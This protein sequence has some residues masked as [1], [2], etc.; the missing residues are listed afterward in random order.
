MGLGPGRTV[1]D[2]AAGT[3]KLSR[4]LVPSG[5]R[6]VAVEPVTAMREL[7]DGL[8]VQAL[9]G[10]AEEIPLADGCAD[11]VTVAQALHWFRVD[12]ALRE[13]HRILRPGGVL[14]VVYN[15]ADPGDPVLRAFR[16]IVRRHRGHPRRRLE[17]DVNAWLEGSALLG[18]VERHVF[19]N[20]QQV[21]AATLVAR[22][23]SES[24]IAVLDGEPR[25]AALAELEE[26][27]RTLPADA[28]LHYETTVWLARRPSD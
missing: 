25:A 23:A 13:I 4:L 26:L 15:E 22:G 7:L 28:F 6:V 24:S 5:A 16:E 27:A 9:P 2:L 8:G 11:G 3:G 12:E 18:G 10:A 19:A 21:D 17:R 20:A 14:A 1:V